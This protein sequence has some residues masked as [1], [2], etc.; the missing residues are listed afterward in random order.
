MSSEFKK[1]RNTILTRIWPDITG[2]EEEDVELELK[3]VKLFMKRGDKP[4]SDGLIGHIKLLSNRTTLDERIC[5]FHHPFFF[6]GLSYIDIYLS[7]CFLFIF[8]VP[9]R[10]AL[11]SI[12]EYS[13]SPYRP[14]FICTGRKCTKDCAEGSYWRIRK[15]R[16]V[17]SRVFWISRR[18]WRCKAPRSCGVCAQ[19]TSER[20]PSIIFR[21][22]TDGDF[23]LLLA[24]PFMFQT[25]FQRI[26]WIAHPKFTFQSFFNFDIRV[27]HCYYCSFIIIVIYLILY[28]LLPP[29]LLF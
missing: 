11:E 29:S 4:F 23:F 25:W 21:L 10:T 6:L 22:E 27:C 2:E 20:S 8:S 17:N 24:W 15:C 3:G 28:N 5:E 7:P 26:R 9:S 16:I 19:G 13:C 12:Y 1:E 18:I 14:M